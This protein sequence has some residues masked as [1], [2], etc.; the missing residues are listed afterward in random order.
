MFQLTYESRLALLAS[1]LSTSLLAMNL[2]AAEPATAE[3]PKVVLLGD[4]IR[5][6]YTDEVTRHLQGRA[7]VISPSRNGGD[8]K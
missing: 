4:S 8:S 7:V 5:L 2:C 3:L 1:V 6:S